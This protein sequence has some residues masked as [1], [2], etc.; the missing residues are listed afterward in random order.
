MKTITTGCEDHAMTV[1]SDGDFKEETEDE[2]E[3]EEEDCPKNF[4]TF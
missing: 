1:E 3:E 4:D 2:I